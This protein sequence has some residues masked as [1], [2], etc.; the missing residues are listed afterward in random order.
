MKQKE[1]LYKKNSHTVALRRGNQG[2]PKETPGVPVSIVYLLQ[3]L[4]GSISTNVSETDSIRKL[5][6]LNPNAHYTILVITI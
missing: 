4:I 3:K 1:I 2:D 5:K 6:V